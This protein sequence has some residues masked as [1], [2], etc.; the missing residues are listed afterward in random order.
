M[1]LTRMTAGASPPTMRL[2]R[3]RWL[4]LPS[5]ELQTTEM[6]LLPLGRF[7]ETVLVLRI[8]DAIEALR[9]P[10]RSTCIHE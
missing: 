10:G 7:R 9:L 1:A 6:G 8:A 4:A 5:E 3:L 2:S